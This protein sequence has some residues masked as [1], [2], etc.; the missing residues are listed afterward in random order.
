[1]VSMKKEWVDGEKAAAV[2]GG[3]A[4]KK[5]RAGGRRNL[6]PSTA[7]ARY[8]SLSNRG[9]IRARVPGFLA[10]EGKRKSKK[11]GFSET[12]GATWGGSGW[13]KEEDD[14]LSALKSAG[15]VVRK[16]GGR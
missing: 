5:I 9:D 7:S 4:S 11:R 1:M 13:G 2:L 16:F 3:R 8:A 15:S 6:V 12:G 14:A 10:D